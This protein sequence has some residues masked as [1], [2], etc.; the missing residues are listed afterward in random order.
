[1]IPCCSSKRV[2]KFPL[3]LL[4][5][6][7]VLALNNSASA[8]VIAGNPDIGLPGGF[9]IEGN[10]WANSPSI[11]PYNNASDWLPN[12]VFGKVGIGVLDASGNPV[13]ATKTFHRVDLTGNN[14]LDV[15]A[16]SDKVFHNPNTYNWKAGSVPQKDD[17]QN[18][19][20]HISVHPITGDL[21]VVMAGDRRAENGDSYIDFEFLQNTLTKNFDGTFTSLGPN[22]GR[23]IGDILLTIELTK[24]GGQA[25]FFVQR[26]LSDGSGGFT[27]VDFTPPAGTAFVA[28]NIDSVVTVPYSP[29]SYEINSFGEAAANLSQLISSLD[30]CFGAKTIWIRTKSSQSKTAQL[31]DMTEPIQ[32]SLCLDHTPPAITCPG[33]KVFD[34]VMGDPG[35]ATAT[36]N[37]DVNPVIT[38]QDVILSARCPRVIQRTWTAKDKCDNSA[39]CVQTI[40]IRDITPPVVTCPSDKVFDCVMGDAGT[41]TA[42]DNCGAVNVSSSDVITSA[43]CPLIIQRTWTAVDTCGN[44]SSCVQTITVQDT[45]K[46]VLTCAA[47]VV[48]DCVMGDPGKATATDNCGAVNVSSSDVITSARC[49]LIIQRTW[50][51]TDTCGNSS[52]CVQTITVQDTTKPVVTCPADK[53]FDCTMGDAGKATATDNCGPGA[54]KS[55]TSNDVITPENE[56]CPLVIQR[57]WTAV[58]TCGN[59]SSCLQIITVQDTTPPVV[60]CPSDKVFDCTMGDPGAATATDNCGPGAIKSL[61]SNDVITHARCPLVIARTWTATDTCGNNSSCVQSITVQDTAKPVVTCPADKV[62]D[63]TMGDAGAATATDNCGPGAIK[64]LTSNDVITNARCPLVIARTWTA[65]DTCGNSSSCVQTITVQDTTKPTLTCQPGK[66]VEC[67]ATIVFD[68]PTP[69][70]NC[71]PFPVICSVKTE[72]IPGPGTGET[73]YTRTWKACDSCGNVSAPCSQSIVKK[74]CVFGKIAPTETT[75]SDFTGGTAGDITQACYGIKSGVINN[76]APGVFFYFTQV[77][78]PSANFTIDIVQTNNDASFPFFAVHNG[79]S[80][81]RL[82][83]GN[84]V[85]S[86]LG[87]ASESPLGQAHVAI[88]GATVGQTFIVQVKY[89]ANSVNGTSVSSPYPTVHYDFHTEI[90]GVTVDLDPDGLD[91]AKCVGATSASAENGSSK[92]DL[93]ANHPNPF[94]ANTTI[95]YS[96]PTD[97]KVTLAVFNILGQKVITLVEGVQAAGYHTVIWNGKNASGNDIASGV[98]FYRIQFGDETQIKRMTLLK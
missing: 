11:P 34:C 9:G 61:T 57:T 62:F 30:P 91:L 79:I 68:D 5:F 14:D 3:I 46:P 82:F 70:D 33:D 24:G 51:A 12:P 15:F 58:D 63:C 19:L 54:I 40:T 98:Y 48:F 13:D 69:S 43:R 20:I 59:F 96:L 67:R 66:T 42:T 93:E 64:S 10:L 27:Y 26:W 28:A 4:A 72:T 85:I 16:E 53:V 56:R 36:D 37:C 2:L 90:G 29:F 50:T 41:A 83:D 73:T 39:S 31:K 65:T 47:N 22:G 74:R 75:C 21:W 76:V 44:S 45:T 88:S 87:T 32:L 52:S 80:E 38:Y 81:I 95:K 94:N 18:G 17:I 97:G 71:D 6:F 60:T 8:V 35:V 89:S 49:P 86:N 77:T 23:T 7:A 25:S 78:A 1:M 92:L 55:L 84:C